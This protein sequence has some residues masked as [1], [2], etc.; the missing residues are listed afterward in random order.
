MN[1]FR[2]ML[3]GASFPLTFK[4]RPPTIDF[5]NLKR[6]RSVIFHQVV[7]KKWKEHTCAPPPPTTHTTDRQ[8]CDL[9]SLLFF[10]RKKNIVRIDVIEMYIFYIS[11]SFQFMIIQ[12]N[13]FCLQFVYSLAEIYFVTKEHCGI[14]WDTSAIG[15]C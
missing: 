6:T 2:I 15:L 9:I 11:N 4:L 3:S 14:E 13:I 8:H 7:F 12:K 10:S 1:S 5:M